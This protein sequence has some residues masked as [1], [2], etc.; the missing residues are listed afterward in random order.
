MRQF[1][2]DGQI[3]ERKDEIQQ[4]LVSNFTQAF[5]RC[6]AWWKGLQTE[7]L[8]SLDDQFSEER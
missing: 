3:V 2:V 7:C 6:R 5:S 4:A 8:Q 1:H